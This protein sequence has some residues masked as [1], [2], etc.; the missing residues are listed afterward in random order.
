MV[1]NLRGLM[2]Q[3]Q[4]HLGYSI[5]EMTRI[6]SHNDVLSNEFGKFYEALSY[7]CNIF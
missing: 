7:H 3:L 4:S 1:L 6:G 5:V 2:Q